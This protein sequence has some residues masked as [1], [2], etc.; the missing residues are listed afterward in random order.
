MFIA[1][2]PSSKESMF[3]YEISVLVYHSNKLKFCH[4]LKSER[5]W[6]QATVAC[7]P[8]LFDLSIL[9][10]L[11]SASTCSIANKYYCVRSYQLD[12]SREAVDHNLQGVPNIRV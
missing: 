10:C 3:N 4:Q 12:L 11:S 1:N 7:T 8:S 5:V 2:S 6:E 9:H